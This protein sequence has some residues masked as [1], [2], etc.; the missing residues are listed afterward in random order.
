MQEI[1]LEKRLSRG[2]LLALFG[3]LA[4]GVGAISLRADT[5]SYSY[6]CR[7][8]AACTQM[9]GGN[10]R[11]LSESGPD[12]NWNKC[13][14]IRKQVIGGGSTPCTCTSGNGPAADGPKV[15]IGHNLQ[16]N[17]VS[18]G[19][20]MMVS[21]IKNPVV[22]QFMSGFTNSFLQTVF[23]NQAEAQRQRQIM[24]QQL[25]EQRRRQEEQRRIAE[26][27]RIDA[28]YARLNRELKLEG[29]PFGLSLKSM[30][31]NAGLELKN[32][33]STGPDSLTLK[34]SQSTPTSYGLKGLPG[35]YV[36][37]PV[38][39]DGSTAPE[40]AAAGNPNLVSGPG[41]GTTGPGI[42]GLPGIYLD[43]V[44]PEQA[45]PLAQ[46]ANNLSGQEQ[47]L[48]QDTAL[49]AAQRNPA[50]SGPSNDPKVQAFQATVQNYDQAA[51]TAKTTQLAYNEAQSRADAD[52]SVIEMARSKLDTAN[53]TSAQQQ[54]FN[55]MLGAAKSDEDAAEA[56]R[57]IF[58]GANAN[59][60]ISRS[61]AA[62]ALAAL[63]PPSTSASVVDP[64]GTSKPMVVANLKTPDRGR[65]P[66]VPPVAA[67]PVAPAPAP[68]VFKTLPTQTQL[69]ARLEGLQESLRRL[70]E[71]ERKRGEARADAAKDVNEA[72]GDAEER[73]LNMLMDLLTTG[74]DNCAPLAQGGVVG[75]FERDAARIPGQIEDVYKEASA[76]K[77]AST[78]GSFNE[79]KEQLDR[80]K[81]WLENS[82][83]QIKRY[84]D[85]MSE[86][87]AAK[88][89]RE[90]I[91]KSN[92]DLETTLD[93]VRKT[94]EMGLDDKPITDYLEHAAGLAGCH[95]VALKA[96]SSVVDSVYD[97]FKEG[98][99][100]VELRDLDENTMKFLTAQK[101]IDRKLKATV[102]QL[103]CYKLA[104]PAGVM[105]CVQAAGQP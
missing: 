10:A 9:M 51:D 55:Q 31:T 39:S 102:A 83:T 61:N 6:D 95:V 78:L 92:G 36:G 101:A 7:G 56:A 84:K 104:D 85:R 46:A 29:V 49:D 72:V 15:A 105:S 57:K 17:M 40:A 59:L 93:G 18:L 1:R 8:S 68:T 77:D 5:C 63:A 27:Q 3:C 69:R 2:L 66:V 19:A 64:R 88:N 99:A 28:M 87:E 23:D 90:V 33:N 24:D 54:A 25:A 35:I 22:G 48:A 43:A 73:G 16:Q 100:A 52:K 58:D 53:A 34:L 103:N 97:I 14:A 91:E 4:L 98:D 12:M 71:D 96:T 41:T 76:A 79:K 62:G 38:G 13:E 50:L 82:V 70:T 30:N 37:G 80:T 45:A 44:K 60:S 47:V 81:I 86:I 11:T 94:I 32:M 42:P 74:W 65:A 75:K 89:T 21:N 26:Q 67:T 20:N